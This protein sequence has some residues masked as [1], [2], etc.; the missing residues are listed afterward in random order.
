MQLIPV[1]LDIYNHISF[2]RKSCKFFLYFNG[3]LSKVVRELNL[4]VLVSPITDYKPPFSTAVKEISKIIPV[5]QVRRLFMNLTIVGTKLLGDHWLILIHDQNQNT[6]L[7]FYI[8]Y[9]PL[10]FG[11]AARD[12]WL[13]YRNNQ[14]QSK[15]KTKTKPKNPQKQG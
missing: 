15:L 10:F 7:D 6:D 1:L 8:T 11:A 5:N 3:T 14:G 13:I 2:P 4:R 9:F 12:Q